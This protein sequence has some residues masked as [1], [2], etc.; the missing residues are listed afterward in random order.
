QMSPNAYR[1]PPTL[2]TATSS[3]ATSKPVADPSGTRSALP[4]LTNSAIP[5][6]SSSGDPSRSL[7]GCNRIASCRPAVAPAAPDVDPDQRPVEQ[8]QEHHPL[9][10]RDRQEHRDEG[11][12]DPRGL[13]QHLVADEDAT[14]RT[15]RG[16]ALH[17][18]REGEPRELRPGAG[19][20]RV[21]GEQR[22]PEQLRC[23]QRADPGR[24]DAGDHD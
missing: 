10:E 1:T 14:E 24:A 9:A 8:R 21:D 11:S 20:R 4:T 16:G 23:E 19:R 7:R 22:Q 15:L 2:A 13:E 12:G 6:P 18:A 3:P 17:Q 5:G